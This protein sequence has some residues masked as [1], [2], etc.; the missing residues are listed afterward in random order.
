[1]NNGWVGD[2]AD[3]WNLLGDELRTRAMTV[4]VSCVKGHAKQID[5]DRGR[6]TKEDKKGNDSADALATA[7]AN[8]HS[9]APEVVEEAEQRMDVALSVQRMMLAILHARAL[10]E[11]AFQNETTDAEHV[12]DRGSDV[13]ENDC[14]NELLCTDVNDHDLIRNDQICHDIAVDPDL[15]AHDAH[16]DVVVGA[17]EVDV[18]GCMGGLLCID[19]NDNDLIRNDPILHDDCA[20][21][22]DL[23]VPDGHA[24]NDDGLV[25]THDS[26]VDV[27]FSFSCTDLDDDF[28]SGSRL[29]SGT[30]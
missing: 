3:L 19:I 27:S 2:H 20:F 11:T 8:M 26:L 14:I 1:M 17:S 9:A 13:D 30:G 5:I 7:G 6:T 23:C 29:L 22:Q 16:D 28:D 21:V 12:A 24:L 10:E 25:G 15:C 18:H 4:V